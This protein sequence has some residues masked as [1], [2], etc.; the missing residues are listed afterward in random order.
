MG[1]PKRNGCAILQ[2]QRLR[3]MI[4]VCR[5]KVLS[6]MFSQLGGTTFPVFVWRAHYEGDHNNFLVLNCIKNFNK[7][8][9]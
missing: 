1:C 6:E 7:K 9:N 3:C 5:N 8:K 2:Y 4:N